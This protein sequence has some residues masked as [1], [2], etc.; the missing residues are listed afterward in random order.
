MLTIETVC[1]RIHAFSYSHT[2]I[3]QKENFTTHV[4]LVLE[5]V[6]LNTIYRLINE[7]V[8]RKINISINE[9]MHPVEVSLE[10]HEQVALKTGKAVQNQ[11][12]QPKINR[13]L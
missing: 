7:T 3:I 5:V 13:A 2:T 12:Q 8:Q 10:N 1:V 6:M 11:R 9:R 4:Q